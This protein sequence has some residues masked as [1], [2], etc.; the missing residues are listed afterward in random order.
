LVARAFC[1]HFTLISVE[2]S[3]LSHY[4]WNGLS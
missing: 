1:C 4:I 2:I 3:I